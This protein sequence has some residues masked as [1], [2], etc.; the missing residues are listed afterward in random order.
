MEAEWKQS[1]SMMTA[2]WKH[3]DRRMEAEWKQND[4]RMEVREAYAAPRSV[5]EYTQNE[6]VMNTESMQ[7]ESRVKRR[8]RL[9]FYKHTP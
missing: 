3:D 9:V 2:E 4:R 5:E 7:N 8:S 1:G 6:S